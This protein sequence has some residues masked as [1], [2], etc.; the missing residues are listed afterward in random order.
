MTHYTI[1]DNPDAP[2]RETVTQADLVAR[3]NELSG[4]SIGA[5]AAD[6]ARKRGRVYVAAA[7]G[8]RGFV[9]RKVDV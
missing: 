6:L 2:V 5:Y 3:I 9:V 4:R 7:R 8:L 1:H